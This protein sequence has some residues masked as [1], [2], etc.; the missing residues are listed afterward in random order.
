[1]M[2]VCNDRHLPYTKDIFCIFCTI[3]DPPK[4][5][6]KIE[7][8]YGEGDCFILCMSYHAPPIHAFT[9]YQGLLVSEII[10]W[11]QLH[12]HNKQRTLIQL[13]TYV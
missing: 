2:D 11:L 13:T 9:C 7:E 10:K 6:V 3:I 8:Y 4:S 12:T 1:M 5:T